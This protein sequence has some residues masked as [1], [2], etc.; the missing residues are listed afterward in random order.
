MGRE[1]LILP[2][3]AGKRK[4]AMKAD[5]WGRKREVSNTVVAVK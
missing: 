1:G 3:P 4:K 2:G 5:I